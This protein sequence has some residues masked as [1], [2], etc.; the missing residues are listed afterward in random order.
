MKKLSHVKFHNAVK[1]ADY[2]EHSWYVHKGAEIHM[3]EDGTIQIKFKGLTRFVPTA[4]V[5]WYDEYQEG[6]GMTG[7]EDRVVRPVKKEAKVI[8]T[9]G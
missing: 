2:T 5:H 4:N 8:G 7:E 9:R 6:Q 1:V 3:M